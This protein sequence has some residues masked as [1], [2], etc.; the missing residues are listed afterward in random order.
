VANIR[1]APL[2]PVSKTRMDELVANL[3]SIPSKHLDA[4]VDDAATVNGRSKNLRLY[5]R[6]L[7]REVGDYSAHLDAGDLIANVRASNEFEF[8]R[9]LAK[10]GAP[11]DRDEWF[12][13]PKRS[14]RT[15]TPDLTRLSFPAILQWPSSMRR[16][17][18]PQTTAE[19]GR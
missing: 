3:S 5:P 10:I 9:E 1:G 13:Y 6:W 19:L 17:T 11:I 7:P 12:M 18:T 8:R 15:T 2:P 4:R 16:A 14:T